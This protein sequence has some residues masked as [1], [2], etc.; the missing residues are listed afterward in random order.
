MW[1]VV[2]L[3]YTCIHRVY[4]WE[5][6]PTIYWRVKKNGKWTWVRATVTG[7]TTDGRGGHIVE[8]IYPEDVESE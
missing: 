3:M 6:E 1:I 7:W 5:V 2:T 4:M 8:P